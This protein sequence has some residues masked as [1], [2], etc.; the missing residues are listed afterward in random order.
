VRKPGSSE[1]TRISWDEALDRIADLMKADRDANFIEK[2]ARA[3]G[4]PLAHHRVSRVGGVQRSGLHHPQGDSQ[5]RHA[6]VR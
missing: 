1:W 2:N 3:N 5:S 4:E 6:G